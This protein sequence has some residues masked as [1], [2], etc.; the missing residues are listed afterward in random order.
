[1]E[2][3]ASDPMP[4][5]Q[6]TNQLGFKYVDLDELLENSNIVTIHCPATEQTRHLINQG[7][8]F[9]M[10]KGAFLINT[11]R[12]SVVETEAIFQA[13]TKSHLAGVA[14]DVLEEE[15]E[16]KEESELLNGDKNAAEF[17]SILE[18]HLLMQAPNVIITPHMAFYTKEAEKTIAKTTLENIQNFIDSKPSNT[19]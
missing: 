6:L 14:V 19:V 4:N 8:I 1:M 2:V 18:D 7:N 3:F 10:K 13:V 12:G 5:E 15:S 11:A 17:K 16:L 9:K